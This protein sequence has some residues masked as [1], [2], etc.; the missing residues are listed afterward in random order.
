M[1]RAERRRPERGPSY[2]ETGIAAPV[3]GL[4]TK[5]SLAGMA[6]DYALV[7]DNWVC[8]PDALVSRLGAEN[9][10]T[11]F[12]VP[13]KSLHRYSS[14]S[15]DD[16]FAAADDGIYDITSAGA[17]GAAVTSL[18]SGQARSVN[19]ST[20]AGQYLVLVNGADNLKLYDGTTWVTVTGVSTPAI[21]GP[22]TET[23]TH[24]ETYRQRLFFLPK[25]ALS[26]Y[27]LPIDSVGGAA[28]EFRIGAICRRGGRVISHATWT[29][30]GGAGS[31]D[32][33]V[34]ATS[35]GE[36][37]VFTGS[38]PSDPTAWTLK[39]VYYIGEPLGPNCLV[40]VGGDLLYLC[41]A[42]LL[43][44]SKALQTATIDYRTALTDNIQPTI[45]L[46]AQVSA[47][48]YGWQTQP[49][50]AMNLLLVNVPVDSDTSEQYCFSTLSRGWSRFTNWNATSWIE[51]NGSLYFTHAGGVAKALTGYSDFGSN[52][53]ATMD[54]AYNRFGTR[55]Q[56]QPAQM[57]FL[58]ATTGPV[59]YTVGFATD[60]SDEYAEQIMSTGNFTVGLWDSGLWDT[61]LWGAGYSLQKSWI[62][63]P[64]YG[65]IALSTRL[66]VESTTIS[67]TLIAMD[68]L[69]L[70]QGLIS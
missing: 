25:Q 54:T 49:F 16:F 6:Q 8:Q 50:P 35:E 67:S 18:I 13:P 9:Y 38:D 26:F 3:K 12:T 28:T 37:V 17:V 29:F 42:G 62:T 20:S 64:A 2:S 22:G 70:R 11:G 31:D 55:R 32:C 61:A 30:D 40:K 5:T 56:L 52:I 10:S 69:L 58:L 33:Y 24:V 15:G 19:F 36:V 53:V 34:V 4:N 44:L 57:R 1:R 43:P 59:Q 66:R 65:G 51:H 39:G 60:F 47:T 48:N 68:Y 41:A 46:A 7:L 23:L 21:T 63:V 14:A 27:Y 45:T